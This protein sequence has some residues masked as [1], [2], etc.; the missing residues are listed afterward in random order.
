MAYTTK[1]SKGKQRKLHNPQESPPDLILSFPFRCHCSLTFF[2]QLFWALL[3]H[4]LL[5]SRTSHEKRE[6][7]VHIDITHPTFLSAVA[8]IAPKDRLQSHPL[9]VSAPTEHGRMAA[10][11]RG[12]I[13]VSE[14]QRRVPR[15]KLEPSPPTRPFASSRPTTTAGSPPASPFLVAGFVPE[16][17]NVFLRVSERRMYCFLSSINISRKG[18]MNCFQ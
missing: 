16:E 17:K 3:L 9:L 8:Q 10:C 13:L 4:E 18:R 11:F 6:A 5:L 2:Q 12:C 1:K 14:V 7:R 15:G